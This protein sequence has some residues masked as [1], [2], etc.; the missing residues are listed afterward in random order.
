[1]IFSQLD[2]SYVSYS[3]LWK[4]RIK[5]FWKL[6]MFLKNISLGQGNPRTLQNSQCFLVETPESIEEPFPLTFGVKNGV[7]NSRY[8][9]LS[10]HIQLAKTNSFRPLVVEKVEAKLSSWKSKVLSQ[11]G[12]GVLVCT[13]ASSLPPYTMTSWTPSLLTFW[14][15]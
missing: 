3:V 14:W 4:P 13:I 1:M 8:L 11:A 12:R 15:G 5:T 2:L 7:A 9:G 10:W 6:W